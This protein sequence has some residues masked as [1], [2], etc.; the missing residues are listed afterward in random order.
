MPENRLP[1]RFLDWT[2]EGFRRMGRTIAKDKREKNIT[3]DVEN[4]AQ[5]RE[6]WKNFITVL[7]AT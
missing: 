6:E 7:W 3:I 2:P 1:R 5:R 4:L